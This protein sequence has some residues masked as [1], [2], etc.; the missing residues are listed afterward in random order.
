LVFNKEESNLRNLGVRQNIRIDL[1]STFTAVKCSS[2]IY[3]IREET[4]HAQ[5]LLL[6]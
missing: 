5:G 3:P 6:M 1:E 4:N 2:V